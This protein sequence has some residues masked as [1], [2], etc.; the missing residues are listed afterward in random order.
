MFL[1]AFVASAL[2]FLPYLIGF[3]IFVS[4]GTDFNTVPI[5]VA[6]L[7]DDYRFALAISLGASLILL[8][9]S[10]HDI[11]LS[12]IR[13]CNGRPTL[14]TVLPWNAMV[15]IAIPALVI[16]SLV[17]GHSCWKLMPCFIAARTLIFVYYFIQEI[18]INGCKVFDDELLPI[19][20]TLFSI[21]RVLA[22]FRAFFQSDFLFGAFTLLDLSSLSIV[23]V[24]CL[25]WYLFCK[26]KSYLELTLEDYKCSAHLIMLLLSSFAFIGLKIYRGKC[27]YYQ[28]D[29]KYLL[30]SEYVYLIVTAIIVIANIHFYKQGLVCYCIFFL[31]YFRF[32]RFY[33]IL[34]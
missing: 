2:C 28:M 1:L 10:F 27:Y 14:R 17:N 5:K 12:V 22:S 26:S 16:S 23:A 25:K 24:C 29:V 11:V 21:S 18:Q 8:L 3:D 32:Y 9:Q 6:V 34:I 4:F 19:V 15:V 31:M 13:K 30:F 33:A 7:D 20:M